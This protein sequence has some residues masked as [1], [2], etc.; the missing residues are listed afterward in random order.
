MDEQKT[1]LP[2]YPESFWLASA[3]IPSSGKLTADLSV[4]V[5]VVG[6]GITGITLAYLLAKEG[7]KV[8]LLEAGR[9]LTGTTGHTTA[10]VTAQHD[11]IYDEFIHHVGE[12]KARLYYDANRQAMDFIRSTVRELDISCDWAEEDAYVYT[13][14][15]QN[16]AKIDKEWKAYEKLGIPGKRVNGIPLP[17]PGVLAAVAMTGQARFHPTAYLSRLV[18]EFVGLG[19]QLFEE[20]MAKTVE[21]G[22]PYSQVVTEDGHRVT[23]RNVASCTHFPFYGAGGFYFARMYSERSYALGVKRTQDYPGGVY[24]SADTPPRSIR[25]VSYGGEDLLVIG[26][27]RHKTGQ[28]IC[29]FQHY[30]ALEKFAQET[31]GPAEIRYRWSAQDLTTLDKIPYVGRPVASE[32]NAFIATGYRK[33]GMTGGTAAALLLKD[34]ILGIRSPYEELYTPSRFHADP[35]VKEFLSLN[36]DVA[37]HLIAGKLEWVRRDPE[38]LGNDEGAA[39]HVNGKRAGAYREPGGALHVLDTTCTHMGCEVEWNDG[40]RTWDCPCHGSRFS[41]RGEVLEGP[42]KKPLKVIR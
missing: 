25:T 42:A 40:E 27:E 12:E 36:A 29:T 26:G 24:L 14:S 13:A 10:K 34:L 41:F 22:S 37:K 8:A 1:G 38:D 32:R 30:E 6:G 33:W 17:I 31:F 19:G 7:Q 35:S 18:R 15:E 39:V 16:V 11:L 5:A 28:G 23:C 3:E 9:I 4:D 21:H 2:Q 20:T